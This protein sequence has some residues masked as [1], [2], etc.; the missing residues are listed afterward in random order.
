MPER[1]Q[2]RGPDNAATVLCK[3]RSTA[4]PTNVGQHHRG[5]TT[6]IT[7]RRAP[8]QW[9]ISRQRRGENASRRIPQKKDQERKLAGE[10]ETSPHRRMRGN[11]F[12]ADFDGN[13]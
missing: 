10:R 1:D 7:P 6:N 9:G 4:T 12:G 5:E 2:A 11:R 8:T 13:R 3:T